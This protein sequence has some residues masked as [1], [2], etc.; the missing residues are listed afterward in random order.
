VLSLSRNPYE[1]LSIQ[2]EKCFFLGQWRIYKAQGMDLPELDQ[3]GEAPIEFSAN[4]S[5]DFVLQFWKLNLMTV[6]II[7]AATV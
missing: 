2:Y 6:W 4:T 1:T 7:A 5:I 3:T